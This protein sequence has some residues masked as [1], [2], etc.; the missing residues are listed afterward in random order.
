MND[1]KAKIDAAKQKID[2]LTEELRKAGL[3]SSW[4]E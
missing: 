1:K 4:A 3:P 2:D